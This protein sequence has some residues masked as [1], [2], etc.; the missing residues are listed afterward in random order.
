L[1]CGVSDSTINKTWPGLIVPFAVSLAE[2]LETKG[3]N[4]NFEI[5]DSVK[6]PVRVEAKLDGL[7]CV[8]V[9]ISGEVTV[10]T[11]NG[12]V[13]ETPGMHNIIQAIKNLPYDNFVLDGELLTN[14]NWNDTITA[15]MK[16]RSNK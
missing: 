10:Y 13:L 12:T 6:Y 14:G 2:T 7:R 3:V 16:G 1:R 5:V 4:G 15:A 11:R 8:A 9:K